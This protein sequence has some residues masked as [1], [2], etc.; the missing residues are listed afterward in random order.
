MAVDPCEFLRERRP[1]SN[2]PGGDHERF[3]SGKAACFQFTHG[4]A[5]MRFEFIEIVHAETRRLSQSLTPT[6][7]R[8]SHVKR[9]VVFHKL[10]RVLWT[11]IHC[12]CSSR[13]ALRPS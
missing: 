6:P 12:S 7:D 10:T 1:F 3:I 2:P 8:S 11:A 13:S 5:Q 9:G 4:I